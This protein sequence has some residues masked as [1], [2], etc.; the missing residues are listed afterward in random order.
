MLFYVALV[1]AFMAL[2]IYVLSDRGT[3]VFLKNFTYARRVR[4]MVLL[5]LA[6]VCVSL[7]TMAGMAY[8]HEAT[9]GPIVEEVALATAFLL[10]A[11]IVFVLINHRRAVVAKA[12]KPLVILAVGAHPDDL[13]IAC[14]AT[15]AKLSDFGHHVHALVMSDGKQGGDNKVRPLEARAGASTMGVLDIE[16]Y[17]LTDTRLA[18]HN[19]DMVRIVEGK[20]EAIK[21]D[22]ILTHS[23]NDQ[24]QD[25][26]AVHFAVLRAA[27]KY[28]SILCFES[29]SVTSSFN[30][31]VFVDI[32]DYIDVKVAAVEQHRDQASKRYLRSDR[33]RG[34]AVFRGAQGKVELAEG[35]E[36]VRLKD[37]IVG[38]SKMSSKV[39]DENSVNLI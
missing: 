2:F 5:C 30:P 4:A 8:I 11:A 23:C 12:E 20:I 35:F 33:I 16:V 17:S 24:H 22:L 37:S 21:P 7:M 38:L 10:L 31:T 6:V 19:M 26:Q 9:W 39:V 27:R 13:E 15:L 18:E 1:I 34:M 29:P 36:V 3:A 25:H 28:P 14:G 32:T